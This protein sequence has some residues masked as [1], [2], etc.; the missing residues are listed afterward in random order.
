[1]STHVSVHSTF[2]EGVYVI[3][4]PFIVHVHLDQFVLIDAVI[5][6]QLHALA[7]LFVFQFTVLAVFHTLSCHTKS[8]ALNAA[9]VQTASQ[10]LHADHD[11]FAS[12]TL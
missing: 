6:S 12:F 9:F 3:L 10:Y 8:E 11:P 1:L 4:S 7:L 5:V 2:E